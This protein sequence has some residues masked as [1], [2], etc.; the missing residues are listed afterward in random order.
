MQL[1]ESYGWYQ[2]H[3]YNDILGIDYINRK[4]MGFLDI[5]LD[6]YADYYYRHLSHDN[7]LCINEYISDNLNKEINAQK[8]QHWWKSIIYNPH[9]KQGYNFAI[10]KYE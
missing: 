1:N 2:Y 3:K 5:S 8:I 6:K 7:D 10:K 9:K 4:S